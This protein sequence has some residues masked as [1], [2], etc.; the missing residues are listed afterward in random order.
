M[1]SFTAQP[2]YQPSIGG[3]FMPGAES[4]LLLLV[5]AIALGALVAAF[6][7]LPVAYGAYALAVLVVCTWSPVAGQPLKSVDRY[8][9]TIFPLWMV[10]GAWVS[11][12]R[13]TRAVVVVSAGLLAFWT[14]QF[15]TW[16]WVA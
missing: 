10:A 4:I 9:L 6:R 3:P 8:T 15:A 14:F 1:R 7:R 5:L 13:L 12:R 2:V 16:A 11:E